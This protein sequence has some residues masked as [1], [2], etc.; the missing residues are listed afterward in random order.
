MFSRIVSKHW[1]N[2]GTKIASRVFCARKISQKLKSATTSMKGHHTVSHAIQR[3][4]YQNVR[5]ARNQSQ[6]KLS[7]L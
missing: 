2:Y 1:K 3:M 4:R 7:K 6:I 5:V